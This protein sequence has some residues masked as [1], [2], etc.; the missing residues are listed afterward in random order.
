MKEMTKKNECVDLLA[1]VK[2]LPKV[3]GIHH[4]INNI[5]EV[6]WNMVLEYS[7]KNKKITDPEKMDFIVDHFANHVN[8]D[9]F[10][11]KLPLTFLPIISLNEFGS[12]KI[13]LLIHI[14]TTG[15]NVRDDENVRC[16]S[17]K[18]HCIFKKNKEDFKCDNVQNELREFLDADGLKEAISEY[19]CDGELHYLPYV[20][21]MIPSYAYES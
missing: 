13:L 17:Y 15:P 11:E 16:D 4:Y 5:M 12:F 7:I 19:E 8:P 14:S 1:M 20:A 21:R 6:Q 10:D 18:H 2:K 9:C 3:S